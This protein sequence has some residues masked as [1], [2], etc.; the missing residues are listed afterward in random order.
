MDKNKKVYI[1]LGVA[2]VVMLVVIGIFCATYF[3]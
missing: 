2:V 3:K 1:L